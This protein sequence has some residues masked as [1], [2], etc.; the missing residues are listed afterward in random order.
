VAGVPE[1]PGT[2]LKTIFG[3]YRFKGI[4]R[5][6]STKTARYVLAM[7]RELGTMFRLKHDVPQRPRIRRVHLKAQGL[8]DTEVRIFEYVL[9]K[10]VPASETC[11]SG[12]ALPQ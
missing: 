1:G 6:R 4:L 8:T 3:R 5:V 11:T 9:Q 10:T 7:H 2:P 12:S